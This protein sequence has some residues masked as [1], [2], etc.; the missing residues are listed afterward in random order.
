M[1]KDYYEILNLNKNC[2]NDEI[3]ENFWILSL[4]YH[5]NRN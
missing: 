1:I 5:P 4:K 2:S 3:C